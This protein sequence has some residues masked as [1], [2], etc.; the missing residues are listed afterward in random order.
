M[1][2][3]P[4]PKKKKKK[5]KKAKT[6]SSAEPAVDIHPVAGAALLALRKGEGEA[7]LLDERGA[8]S[9]GKALAECYEQ[10]PELVEAVQ[11]LL[12]LA[13]YLETRRESAEAAT[14]LLEVAR[15][16]IPHLEKLG[17]D[18]EEIL[19]KDNVEG[20]TAGAKFKKLVGEDRYKAD[21]RMEKNTGGVGGVLG[22]LG[23]RDK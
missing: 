15:Q 8:A 22:L 13:Y 7:L 10:G 4:A 19:N 1:T 9:V 2:D 12:A 6:P 17:I 11:A 21:P 5:K 3:N 18:V 23:K 14:G 16:A 20:S